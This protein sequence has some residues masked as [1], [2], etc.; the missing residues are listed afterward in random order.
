LKLSIHRRW[1]LRLV[2]ILEQD[3]L[4]FYLNISATA[5]HIDLNFM[6]KILNYFSVKAEALL[7]CFLPGNQFIQKRF[8][9]II[10]FYNHFKKF[11]FYIFINDRFRIGLHYMRVNPIQVSF[12][13]FNKIA[14]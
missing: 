4:I 11:S 7:H 2:I 1:H 10:F 3:R 14:R 6:H 8:G 12:N 9:A 13:I 5:Q